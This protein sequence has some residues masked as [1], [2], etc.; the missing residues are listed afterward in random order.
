MNSS[1]RNV[2]RDLPSNSNGCATVRLSRGANASYQ[3][4]YQGT[5]SVV[6]C[7]IRSAEA[8]APA[9]LDFTYLL[10][11][12]ISSRL[13]TSIIAVVLALA[14]MSSATSATTFTGT[15]HN[16]TTGKPAA[17]VDV[18]LLSLAGSMESVANAKT[19]AQGKYQLTYNPT[20]QMPLLVRAI[21]KGVNFHAMMPPG[22]I[23][24]DVQ[25]YE[26]S[27]SASTVQM[28][29]RLIVF[30]PNGSVLAVDEIYSIQNSSTPPLAYFKTDG[31]FEFQT[32]DN[33]DKM[34]VS[35]QGPERMPLVQGA[36][37]RG[38]NRYA[39][40]YAFRPG[41]SAVNLSYQVPYDGNKATI[42][43]PTTYAADKVVILAPPSVSVS[44]NGFGAA[45]SEQGMSVY[46]RDAIP[47]G[48]SFDVSVSGTAPLPPSA[49]QQ[50]QGDP[51]AQG[52]DAGTAVAA[53]PPRLDT[54]KW[55]LLAG[56]GSIFL[57]GA[58]F[59]FRKPA[60]AAVPTAQSASLNAAPFQVAAVAAPQTFAG[61]AATQ[62]LGAVDREVGASLDQL[63]DTLFR[64]ELR[65]QAGTISEQE[66]AE[67]RA[68]AEKILRDLVKG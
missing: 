50:G 17:G 21:Y 8:L 65:H 1:P 20:G 64:L 15:V 39:I 6:P 5:T 66:Y 61:A 67:Q 7:S 26:P 9:C 4:S 45:G 35:A 62:P 23:T 42:H 36:I 55:I 14:L 54:L 22:T 12:K 52:R 29:T 3:A 58:A 48:S 11:H 33:A 49:D 25:V 31:D 56:F 51:S 13:V 47:A 32:P 60:P 59:L 10:I 40:A 53:V 57:L 68:R 38:K 41:D 18:V 43:F 16:G 19:D 2:V 37:D 27:T 44:S 28:P 63:K 34:T 30:Q 24:A 46:T